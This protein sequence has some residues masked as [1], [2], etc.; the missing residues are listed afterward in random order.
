M[1]NAT[2][3]NNKIPFDYSPDQDNDEFDLGE[4]LGILIDGKWYIILI[5]IVFLF[6]GVAKAFLD[7]PVYKVDAMLQVNEKSQTLAGLE[8]LTD[9]LQ[10]KMPILAEIEV[11]ESRMILGEAVKNLDLD[12]I[13]KPKYFPVI[14]EAIA[15]RFQQ[16]N[17]DNVVSSPLFGQSRY[18]WGGEAIQIEMLTIPANWENQELILV[19]GKQGHFQLSF[20][21]ELILEG[22]VG[23]LVSKQLESH[24]KPVTIFVSLLKS[25]PDTQFSIIRQSASSAINQLK[26]NLAVREKGKNTAILELTLESH[27]PD[28]AVKVL[29]EIVNIYVQQSVEHKSAESQKTLAF[30]E[31]Q[32]PILKE[33]LEAASNILNDYRNR[34]GSIDLK[35]E[36]RNILDSIVEITTQE[37]LLRQR[38]DEL[39][40]R[41]TDAHPAVVAVDRQI[42]RLQEQMRSHDAM[43]KTLPKTQQVILELSSDVKVK[44]SLYTTLLN[45]A[46]TLRVA[47]EG[48][49]GD[50]R[51][52][53]YAVLPGQLIKPNKT[54][55]I[56]VALILG[57]F[58]GIMVVFIRKFLQRGIEDP[59]LIEK[60]LNIPVYAT[61]PHS[62]KQ[63]KISNRNRKKKSKTEN[64]QQALLALEAKEDMAIESLRS[65]RTTLHFALLE[66]KN[67]IILF[68]GPSPG[69]GK[70]FITSNLATI[71]ADAGKRILLI[72]GDMR[73]GLINKILGVSRVNGLS[74]IILN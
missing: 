43:V 15:R 62:I 70:T 16:R 24:Q 59:D 55:I 17:P 47:K 11:I 73:K 12:I 46:Q 68:T 69:I 56:G 21:N 1:T 67:N 40:Q 3:D 37:T 20:G 13:A 51:I 71:M 31:K 52:I 9:L 50:V 33:Q 54:L 74:E 23:K 32:L 39:R 61:V 18:A 63:E 42:A 34:K 27:S 4:L 45:N 7:S 44:T 30:L 38:R 36:T 28:Y 72:D 14:G 26:N 19:A 5:A 48:T 10:N 29:N 6:F 41:Y 65:L 2:A 57:L 25:R 35:V 53:D 49:V 58:L 60:H 8:P 22:E 64:N 66:A